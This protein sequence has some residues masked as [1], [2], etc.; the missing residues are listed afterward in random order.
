MARF[1]NAS[2]EPNRIFLH[3]EIAALI[4]LKRGDV[5]YKIKVERYRKDGSP[6]IAKPCAVCQAAINHWRIFNV[7]HT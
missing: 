3:A 6:A 5:P 7:E 2:G 1:A 4:K